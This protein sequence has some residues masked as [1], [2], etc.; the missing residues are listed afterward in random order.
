MSSPINST[1]SIN[2]GSKGDVRLSFHQYI[3]FATSM[4]Q[5]QLSNAAVL[6]FKHLYVVNGWN[7]LSI[8]LISSI[9]S[10]IFSRFLVGRVMRKQADLKIIVPTFFTVFPA[11]VY[12]VGQKQW[13]RRL[14][15]ELLTDKT[16]DGACIRKILAEEKPSLWREI[17]GQLDRLGYNI[18]EF[19]EQNSTEIPRVLI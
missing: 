2:H 17:S 16:D 4:K 12:F 8:F 10:I 3:D 9:P 1:I 15:T 11:A 14:Y 5:D 13:P 18:D 6:K 19:Q 7:V